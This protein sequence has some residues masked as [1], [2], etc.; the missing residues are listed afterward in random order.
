M[1]MTDVLHRERFVFRAATTH[2]EEEHARA[3]GLKGTDA[4]KKLT[5]IYLRR[6][7]GCGTPKLVKDKK[8]LEK[9]TK[10]LS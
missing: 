4:D 2:G 7:D 1:Y 3:C 9:K 8:L 6:G 10:F 5:Q